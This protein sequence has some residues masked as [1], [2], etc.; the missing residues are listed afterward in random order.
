MVPNKL[1]R[2]D[3]KTQVKNEVIKYIKGMDL[4]ENNKLPREEQLCEMMGVSRITLR[5]VL[6]ELATDGV[7][8]RKQGKGTFVNIESMD[9]KVNFNPVM[10]FC[11]MIR[12]SGFTPS[13]RLAESYVE[14]VSEEIAQELG[15]EAGTKINVCK[16]LF[17]AD[18]RLCACCI[19][20]VD[21]THIPI[22]SLEDMEIY[23]DSIFNF[24]YQKAGIKIMWDR[25]QIDVVQGA[26]VLEL[27]ELI[28]QGECTNKP[29]LLLKGVNYDSE[30]RPMIYA[31]EY[32]DTEIIKF[33]QIRRR[34]IDYI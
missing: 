18:D 30:D 22:E 9:I 32:I 11:D 34:N 1:Q 14:E 24:L 7:I 13:T 12:K 6:N 29:Y 3:L 26:D 17:F 2:V 21:L 27:S 10:H 33:N 5:A 19:D 4:K 16:K 25:V 20:Y 23:R 8:F 28:A 15:L 31:M